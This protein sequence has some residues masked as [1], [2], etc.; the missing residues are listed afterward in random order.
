[1][2]ERLNEIFKRVLEIDKFDESALKKNIDSW[3]SLRHINLIV[4]L[5][6]EFDISIEPEEIE[7]MTDFRMVEKIVSSKIER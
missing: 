2:T 1:M 4:E 6:A 3:D 5:E 7:L